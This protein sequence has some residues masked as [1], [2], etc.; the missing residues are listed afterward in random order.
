MFEE[1]KI[2]MKNFNPKFNLR[3]VT[4]ALLITLAACQQ[5][6]EPTKVAKTKEELIGTTFKA[7]LALIEKATLEVDQLKYQLPQNKGKALNE[8]SFEDYQQTI[9]NRVAVDKGEDVVRVY[10][11]LN[12][13]QNYQN[14]IFAQTKALTI[15]D[16]QLSSAK[17]A[18]DI[19]LNAILNPF[20]LELNNTNVSS[21][22]KE[23]IR[24]LKTALTTSLNSHFQE[25]EKNSKI[26]DGQ[27]VIDNYSSKSL[28]QAFQKNIN[29]VEQKILK[30]EDISRDEKINLLLATTQTYEKAN[31]ISNLLPDS[32]NAGG[33]GGRVQWSWK[34][35]FKIAAAVVAVATVIVAG[36]Y[37]GPA[38][39]TVVN[40][41]GINASATLIAAGSTLGKIVG[42]VTVGSALTGVATSYIGSKMY[43]M[44]RLDCDSC[45]SFGLVGSMVK[46]SPFD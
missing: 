17:I 5:N 39:L 19:D 24:S 23:Y 15:L 37:L 18:T 13:N 6:G 14:V 26:I 28:L 40:S 41:L 2:T 22:Y 31:I 16:S 43:C 27:K 25:I 11:A 9:I 44:Q 32:S 7:D 10:N 46:C 42:G 21:K 1:K 34:K 38:I 30:D 3:K 12:K 20:D 8:I 4:L 29:E 36:V 45:D 33:E 35:F